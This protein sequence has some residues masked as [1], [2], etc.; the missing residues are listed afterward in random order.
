MK[1]RDTEL[2]QAGWWSQARNGN[3]PALL[4]ADVNLGKE[5]QVQNLLPLLIFLYTLF[6]SAIFLFVLF[7]YFCFEKAVSGAS[8]VHQSQVTG[9][10]S[11]ASSKPIRDCQVKR[12][13]KQE[14][15]TQD[16][17]KTGG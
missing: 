6:L 9:D 14:T 15:T 3:D 12:A 8:A 2:Q 16:S 17:D 7:F 13:V 10:K 4:T 5:I 11:I 1:Q